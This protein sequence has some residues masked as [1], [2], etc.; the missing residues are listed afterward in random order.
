VSNARLPGDSLGIAAPAS[1]RVWDPLVRVFHWS[2][3]AG[4][5]LAWLTAEESE[6]WHEVIGWSVLAPVAVRLVWGLVGPRTARFASFVR[7]PGA[8]LA[9][10]GRALAGRAERHLGHNPLGGWMV[11]LLLATVAATGLTGWLMSG[12]AGLGDEAMDLL[13]EVHEALASGLLALVALH[14]AGVVWSGWQHGENLARAM[15]TGRK[16]APQGDDVA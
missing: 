4:I 15:F 11:L 12:G 14:V 1:V 7:G 13:E 16:R 6:R 3:A 9:Y 2:L 10:A 8:V 5:A